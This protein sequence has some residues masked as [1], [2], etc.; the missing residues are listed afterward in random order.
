MSKKPDR[1]QIDLDSSIVAALAAR[2][3]QPQSQATTIT[4]PKATYD[5]HL[6]TIQAIRDI[7]AELEVPVYAVAQKLLDH[8]LGEHKLGRLELR[9][10]P[11][12]TVW[13]LE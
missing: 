3:G 11:A 12:T 6:E 13:R 4:R 2:P 9:R 5:L 10:Q 1:T 8:A 7:A